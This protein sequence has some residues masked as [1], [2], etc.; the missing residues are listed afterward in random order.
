[1]TSISSDPQHVDVDELL[2]TER[3]LWLKGPPHET[4][5]QYAVLA[6]DFTEAN[7]QL[8]PSMKVKRK[9]AVERNRAAIE[10]LYS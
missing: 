1:M 10:A 2:V 9:V 8:T 3:E 6:E 5:K 4:I 7:G